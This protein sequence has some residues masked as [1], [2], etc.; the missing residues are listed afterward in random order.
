MVNPGPDL[1]DS[2]AELTLA[3]CALSSSN[4]QLHARWNLVG[5]LSG[6]TRPIAEALASIA[7]QYDLSALRFC[8]SCC[9]IQ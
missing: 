6:A 2:W 8:G 9:I 5:Y 7:G 3:D 4:I 1:P